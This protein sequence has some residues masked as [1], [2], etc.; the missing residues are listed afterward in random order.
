MITEDNL[1]SE[2][3]R[4]TDHY[5][6]SLIQR[7]DWAGAVKFYEDNRIELE[8]AGST[9]TATIHHHAAMA[10][11]SLSDYQA[12]LKA[13]RMAQHIVAKH[14]DNT[15]AAEIFLTLGGILRNLG[16]QK[17]AEKAFR[18]A[19]SIFRRHEC[20]EGQ[21]RAL[22]LLAG[23]LYNVADYKNA[24]AILMDALAIVHQLDDRTKLAYMM[25]N[26]GR[27][28]TF[29]GDFNE[30]EKHLKI[31]IE[32]STELSDWQEVARAQ[33]ALGYLYI[34]QGNYDNAKQAL[35]QG[36]RHLSMVDNCR[37]KVIYL[38]YLGE[39]HY[40]CG[41]LPEASEALKAACTM[42]QKIAPA[43][44]LT[45]RVERHLAEL[46][47]RLKNYPAVLRFA[48]NAMA[49]MEK[50][51]NKVETG[52]LWKIKALV[53]EANGQPE[54]ART[55]FVKSID[56][57]RDAGV[58]LE[59]AQA[60]VSAGSSQ[61]FNARQRL[62]YLFRAEEFYR[63]NSCKAQLRDLERIINSIDY[64]ATAIVT[65]DRT[66]APSLDNDS[67]Y[68]TNCLT[69]KRF[70]T[71]LPLIA[72][73]DLPL[74]LIG[75]TGVGKDRMARYYHHT[76]RPS[77]PFVAVNCASLP[78]TLLESELF[79]YRKGAFTGADS[80]KQG[81]FAAAN[82]GVLY[83]DE[84]SD[85]PLSLQTKLLAILETK[86]VTPLGSTDEVQLDVKLVAATNRNLEEMIE[87]GTF[88][89]DLYYR[90]SGFTW[91]IPDLR[92]R[93]E[94]IPLLLHYFMK[95]YNL[96][97]SDSKIPSELIHQFVAYDWP[98]NT[99]ELANKVKHL[100]VMVE[101]A[102]NWDLV[103]LSRSLFA[104]ESTRTTGS[105]FERVQQFERQMLVEAL[106]AAGGNKSRAAR[107]LQVHEATVRTKLKRYN[108]CIEGGVVH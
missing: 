12:A 44:I 23:L 46:N 99:R 92:E 72:R 80:D 55:Y 26:I 25:G 47:F 59:E 71:Q 41:R 62:A 45:A 73:S 68:L 48:A 10:Y 75:K 17:E 74:L 40:R 83:L 103:E 27:I 89:E 22:N 9:A 31:N 5:M 38:T 96:L 93:K 49:V 7:R 29:L 28:Y 90:L 3:R 57:L 21:S 81:L 8:A 18:D 11:A 36:N 1:G 33:L 97:N 50:A 69:I 98:G 77:G 70:K 54:E 104:K 78:E 4:V 76:I 37:D 15:L 94:D 107:I 63:R 67:D 105:L 84:I 20:P 42:A 95:K 58:L 102:A 52:A 16:E 65:K 87:Q 34:Q 2:F 60:L 32:L 101:Y 64:P 108:I 19:E 51:G 106:V 88:R 66:A 39:L 53:A 86:R 43:T 6:A 13:A 24:L 100:K 79:G 91:Q 56:T 85:I 30:A 35:D 82:G 61:L 14:G